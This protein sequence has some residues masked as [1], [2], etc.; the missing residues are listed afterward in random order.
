MRTLVVVEPSNCA[1]CHNETLQAI[2]EMARV[3][4]ARSVFS[5]GCLVVE[6]EDEPAAILS[7]VRASD[8]AVALASNGERVMVPV[9]AREVSECRRS[10]LSDAVSSSCSRPPRCQGTSA[11]PRL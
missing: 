8:H 1:K 2:S 9:E 5:A 4:S 3:N 7:L 10:H 11:T 6:H